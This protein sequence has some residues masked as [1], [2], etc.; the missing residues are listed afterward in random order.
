LKEVIF[1]E[2]TFQEA[3]AII[4]DVLRIIQYG[5]YPRKT[6]YPARC[7]DCCYKNICV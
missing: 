5:Y 3:R 2:K 6:K 1:S 4:E 7:I